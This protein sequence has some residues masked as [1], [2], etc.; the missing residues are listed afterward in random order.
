MV[1]RLVAARAAVS[2]V[3]RYAWLKHW[4]FKI[5]INAYDH[6]VY[7][8]GALVQGCPYCEAGQV[9]FDPEETAESAVSRGS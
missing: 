9:S 7:V 4:V 8:Q 3:W 6:Y 2:A 1:E 5:K